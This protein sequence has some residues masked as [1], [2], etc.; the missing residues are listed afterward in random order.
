[1]KDGQLEITSTEKKN[2]H[3]RRR[4]KDTHHQKSSK[5]GGIVQPFRRKPLCARVNSWAC[6][7]G[8]R[9]S[10]D[11]RQRGMK[12]REMFDCAQHHEDAEKMGTLKD[13]LDRERSTRV[14]N[15]HGGK[16]H[17]FRPKPKKE[18]GAGGGVDM[19]VRTDSG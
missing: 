13:L 5:K 16:E 12:F 8:D 2:K 7:F 9:G 19:S 6:P 17:L 15:K 10:E 3:M 11:K 1:L 18:Q 4:K 14:R